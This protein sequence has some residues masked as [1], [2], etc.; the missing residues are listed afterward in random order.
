MCGYASG[1]IC[2]ERTSIAEMGNAIWLLRSSTC[3]PCFPICSSDPLA[4]LSLHGACR[5]QMCAVSPA[6]N[7]RERHA[8]PHNIL[9]ARAL[10]LLYEISAR[11][12]RTVG[13]QRFMAHR[14]IGDTASMRRCCLVHVH[15]GVVIATACT[16]LGSALQMHHVLA[17]RTRPCYALND[18]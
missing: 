7:D 14:R 10:P 18:G 12:R 17:E 9:H 2:I 11:R 1:Y 13:L 5:A 4:S 16:W 8:K 3:V 6:P 15:A